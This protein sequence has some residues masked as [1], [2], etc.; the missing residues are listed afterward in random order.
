[1]F[2]QKLFNMIQVLI[3]RFPWASNSKSSITFCQNVVQKI[4]C[5]KNLIKIIF[6]RK[7]LLKLWSPVVGWGQHLEGKGLCQILPKKITFINSS[8]IIYSIP[9]V[10]IFHAFDFD[11]CLCFSKNTT[12]PTHKFWQLTRSSRWMLMINFFDSGPMATF[13]SNKGF[14]DFDVGLFLRVY[15]PC[16]K[17]WTVQCSMLK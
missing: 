1:M 4:T 14:K 16:L 5:I 9:Q 10:L 13:W 17:I 2:S 11:I 12:R 7:S 15:D 6:S 8:V 3:F